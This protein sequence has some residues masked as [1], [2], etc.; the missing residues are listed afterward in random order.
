[1]G[2]AKGGRGTACVQRQPV[3]ATF[4]ASAPAAL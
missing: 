1:M 4:V 3:H 2:I